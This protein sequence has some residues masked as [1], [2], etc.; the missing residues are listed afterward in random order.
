[1]IEC[2]FCSYVSGK[3]QRVNIVYEDDLVLAMMA[4]APANPG[5]VWI[6][7]RQHIERLAE[8]DE[9][10]G[11][12]MFRV[13]MRMQRA[14]ERSGIRCEGS[15]L[16]LAEGEGSFQIVPHI[17][18]DV[19]PRYRWDRYYVLAVIDRPYSRP[20]ELYRTLF[21]DRIRRWA[22][23]LRRSHDEELSPEKIDELA[24]KI[25]DSY[26]TIWGSSQ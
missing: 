24:A 13:A 8:M 19:V 20:D 10:T 3:D 9:Q 6:T 26:K 25:R 15:Y 7:P 11:M 21:D 4:P 5:H 2:L 23:D 18:M 22:D 17:Y 12:Q 1:M 16:S 14:I